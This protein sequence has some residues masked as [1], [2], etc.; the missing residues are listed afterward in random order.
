MSYEDIQKQPPPPPVVD[1][2][3]I[4]ARSAAARAYA[5]ASSGEFTSPV[6]YEAEPAQANPYIPHVQDEEYAL[7]VKTLT[8]DDFF[9]SLPDED[10]A[11]DFNLEGLDDED[12]DDD[13]DDDVSPEKLAK[14]LPDDD[15]E[16][17]T[18]ET[19]LGLLMEEELEN[20]VASLLNSSNP[21]PTTP[22]KMT[23]PEARTPLRESRRKATTVTESQMGRLKTLMRQ[24]YQLLVQQ[25]VLCIR[26]ATKKHSH[27]GESA[28]DLAE[29]LD[30]A[31]GMLQDLDEASIVQFF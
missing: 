19:E 15:D 16:P 26:S 27:G 14:L 25:C 23:E 30:G 11:D 10:D 17:F 18:I 12:D 5:L 3:V 8:D 6:K 31:V 7:F 13:T 9:R 28:D 29:I 1:E 24:H 20:A 22:E 21:P 4:K 2:E